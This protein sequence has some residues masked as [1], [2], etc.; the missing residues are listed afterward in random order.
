MT[1]FRGERTPTMNGRPR[2]DIPVDRLKHRS[3]RKLAGIARALWG[4]GTAMIGPAVF[5][6]RKL[7][8]SLRTGR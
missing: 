5:G 4:D 6:T 1:P 8:G 3:I 2:L 7:R